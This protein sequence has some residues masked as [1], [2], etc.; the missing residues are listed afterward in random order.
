MTCEKGH[1]NLGNRARRVLATATAFTFLCQN[2]AWAVCADGS[3]FPANGFVFG[4]PPTSIWSPGVFFNVAGSTFIPDNSVF[5][6]NDPAQPSTG[7]GHNWV[8]DQGS[9]LCKQT[10]IGPAGGAP[11][12]WTLSTNCIFLQP[13]AGSSGNPPIPIF[14]EGI[15]VPYQ[16]DAVT[17]TCDPTQ[18]VGGNPRVGP[19]LPTNTYFNHLGCSISHGAATAP[20]TAITYLFVAGNGSGLWVVPLSNVTNPV[21]GGSAGKVVGALDWFGNIP[22]GQQL[23]SATVSPDGQFALA[24]TFLK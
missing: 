19:A 5:E 7:G 23:V 12:A 3:T 17:P 18:Y 16:G 24:T 9:G 4:Q 22:L 2:F 21:V 11:T 20:Q 10:D 13:L 8:F 14:A 6:H 15:N 1:A